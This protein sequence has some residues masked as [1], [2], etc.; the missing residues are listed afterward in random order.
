MSEIFLTIALA[1]AA[2]IHLLPVVGVLSV[3]HLER[4]YAIRVDGPD[5]AVLLRHRALMFGVLGALLVT[6][7]VLPELRWPMVIATLISD[8]GFALL[9]RAHPGT[10][11]ALKR[12]LRA[13]VVSIALLVAAALLLSI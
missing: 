13:D 7:I 11:G 9:M 3:D 10:D 2:I 4:L 12:V 6:A 1:G 5:L 8:L